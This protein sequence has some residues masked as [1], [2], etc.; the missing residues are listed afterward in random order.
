MS[1]DVQTIVRSAEWIIQQIVAGVLPDIIYWWMP[2]QFTDLLAT[3][4][5]VLVPWVD[6]DTQTSFRIADMTGMLLVASRAQWQE[7][8]QRRRPPRSPV[9]KVRRRPS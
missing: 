5:L 1:Q 9:R 3:Q 2:A 7:A 6:P 4:D 8:M